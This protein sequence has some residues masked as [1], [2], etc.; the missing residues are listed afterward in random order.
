MRHFATAILLFLAAPT[1]L[2]TALLDK[3]LLTNCSNTNPEIYRASTPSQPTQNGDATGQQWQKVFPHKVKLLWSNPTEATLGV[4]LKIHL[5]TPFAFVRHVDTRQ[6]DGGDHVE[7]ADAKF[8][9]APDGNTVVTVTPLIMGKVRYSLSAYLSSNSVSDDNFVLEVA[10]PTTR[11]LLFWPDQNWD[12]EHRFYP[13]VLHTGM[14]MPLNPVI[15]LAANP[16]K[17]LYIKNFASFTAIQD[18]STPA[19]DLHPDG[20]FTGL[21]EGKA[22]I[23]VTFAGFT[24]SLNVEVNQKK[25]LL[26]QPN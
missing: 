21:H 11:P 17:L 19:I 10:P 22:T 24:T 20:S 13:M 3:I 14:T 15:K 16:D 25:M 26:I 12:S 1:A 6:W 5:A 9:E 7:A 18:P 2:L 4:A 23:K 8:E